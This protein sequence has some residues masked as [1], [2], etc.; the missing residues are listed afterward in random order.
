MYRTILSRATR[1]VPVLLIVSFLTLAMTSLMPG[2]PAVAILGES[3]TPADVEAVNKSLGFDDPLAVRYVRWLGDVVTGDLGVSYRTQQRVFD[4]IRER[5]PVTVQLAIGA[6]LIALCVSIVAGTF[7]A[8]RAGGKADRV[9]SALM[10]SIVAVP[11]FLAALLLVFVFSIKLK[12]T[13]VTGWVNLTQ[14]PW[15]NLRSA[16]LPML[17][18]ALPEIAAYTRILRNDVLATLQEDYILMA[19]SKGLGSWY[20]L[21][22]HALRPS[23]LSLVTLSGVSFG[24]LIAGAVI[25]EQIFALPGLGQLVA[26]SVGEGRDIIM[27]QGIVMFV[28]IVYVL[29]NLLVDLLYA[30]LDPRIRKQA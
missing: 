28:A 3:A 22:R 18:L 1:I 2:G 21:L 7:A 30:V 19:R 24:R 4:A 20:I 17:A 11:G 16:A 25:V 15:E 5:L 9:I 27:V 8:S 26:R 29:L 23:S 14:D 6:E 13:P 10:S 12:W